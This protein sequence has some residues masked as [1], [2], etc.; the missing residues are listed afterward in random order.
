MS[1]DCSRSLLQWNKPVCDEAGK[2]GWNPLHHAFR[3]NF[4]D[5]VYEILNKKRSLAY[6]PV[7]NTSDWTIVFGSL[8]VTR[9]G[10]HKSY[11]LI[12]YS[13]HLIGIQV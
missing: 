9:Q 1:S 12:F 6:L 7:G 13:M 5:L 4:I 11:F 3:L 2:W 10:K 8:M